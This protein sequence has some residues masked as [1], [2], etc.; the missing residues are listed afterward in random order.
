MGACARAI[1][2]GRTITGASGR[3]ITGASGRAVAARS[4]GRFIARTTGA[5][6]TIYWHRRTELSR[7]TTIIAA[8]REKLLATRATRWRQPNDA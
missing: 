3:A 8:G 4:E 7:R 1:A 2:S 6:E 5:A